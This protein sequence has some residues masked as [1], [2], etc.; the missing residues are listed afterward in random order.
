MF[1]FFVLL[2]Y[3]FKLCLVSIMQLKLGLQLIL[4]SDL[5][6]YY[7]R[8]NFR[9]TAFYIHI[10]THALMH[11]QTH[12]HTHAHTH[13][14]THVWLLTFAHRQNILVNNIVYFAAT[15]R[16]ISSYTHAGTKKSLDLGRIK[17]NRN[18]NA[19]DKNISSDFRIRAAC[20]PMS[21]HT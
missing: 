21:S 7:I 3:N 18:W 12:I 19:K 16:L 20:H 13:A 11:V 8:S 6:C 5:Q 1:P 4:L 2:L 10:R 17:R 14:Y 15:I 9:F